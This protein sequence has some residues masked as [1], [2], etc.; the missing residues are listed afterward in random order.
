MEE[1]LGYFLLCGE[2]EIAV[3]VHCNKQLYKAWASSV[4]ASLKQRHSRIL[5]YA[6]SKAS[7][8]GDTCVASLSALKFVCS[9]LQ[10]LQGSCTL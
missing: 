10:C 5:G 9:H 6:S 4:V 1:A 7:K 2:Q 3:H 8:S